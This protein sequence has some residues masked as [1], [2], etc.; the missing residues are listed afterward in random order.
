VAVDRVDRQAD[1]LRVLAVELG[2]ARANSVS[3]VEHTGVK[4]AGW[5]NRITH[6]PS[7]HLESQL[8]LRREGLEVGGEVAD[9][10]M[11]PAVSWVRKKLLAGA[12]V[13]W[14][15]PR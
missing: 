8:S 7:C 3:S 9:A 4:S 2:G 11:P 5:L 10:R 6:L 12:G 13:L 15:L 1:E 14:R